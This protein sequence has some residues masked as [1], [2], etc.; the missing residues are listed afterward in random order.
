MKREDEENRKRN[1]REIWRLKHPWL[2][3]SSFPELL[4]QSLPERVEQRSQGP[5]LPMFG[6]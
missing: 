2:R 5:R 1:S 6:G 4:P 3:T